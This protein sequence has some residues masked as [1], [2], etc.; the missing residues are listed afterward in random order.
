MI[1]AL[2]INVTEL[3]E[4]DPRGGWRATA[5]PGTMGSTNVPPA[6][7]AHRDPSS[8]E[9]LRQA[10]LVRSRSSVGCMPSDIPIRDGYYVPEPP[11]DIKVPVRLAKPSEAALEQY[12]WALLDYSEQLTT[13][14][15]RQKSA[16][17]PQEFSGPRPEETTAEHVVKA[18]LAIKRYGWVAHRTPAE[19][20]ALVGFMVLSP[21]AGVIGS[22]LNSSV[23]WA[24]F[25]AT[26]FLWVV[27]L[28]FLFWRRVL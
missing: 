10:V 13:E 1:N 11:D 19:T 27:C 4:P 6:G 9:V 14:A 8:G 28:G 20:T 2:S 16:G 5:G 18:Y 23:Q 21:T 12:V 7:Y 15:G 17:W 26:A 24:A 22:Y 3:P 25:S